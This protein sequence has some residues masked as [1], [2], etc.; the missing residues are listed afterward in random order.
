MTCDHKFIFPI[1]TI[2]LCA[3][4][5]KS[6]TAC[7]THLPIFHFLS[8]LYNWFSIDQEKTPFMQTS[9]PD[10]PSSYHGILQWEKNAKM[11][12]NNLHIGA[13][14]TIR[15]STLT[16]WFGLSLFRLWLHSLSSCYFLISC[17]VMTLRSHSSYILWN[18]W[19]KGLSRV[20]EEQ[21]WNEAY[22]HK[23]T[24]IVI[25]QADFSSRSH[26][27]EV[28]PIWENYNILYNSG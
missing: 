8:F 20:F 5:S 12:Q 27:L 2:Q 13:C 1:A 25:R 24:Q 19:N 18:T 4:S 26:R 3:L 28:L 21:M 10:V 16:P 6:A 17:W 7:G 14:N 11:M 23:L 22:S 15:V 9:K